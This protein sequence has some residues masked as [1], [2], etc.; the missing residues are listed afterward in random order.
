[1]RE[2]I[3]KTFRDF[4]G[5]FD[6]NVESFNNTQKEKFSQLE[7][8]QNELIANTEKKLEQMRETVDEKLQ[9][10]SMKGLANHL[11]LSAGICLQCRKVWAK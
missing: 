11:K 8:K 1:M 7:I 2:V 3:E 9:R 4:Q 6:R 5:T 10:R